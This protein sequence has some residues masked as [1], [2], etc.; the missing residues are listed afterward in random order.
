MDTEEACTSGKM[1]TAPAN[2]EVW[3]S[4]DQLCSILT[5]S[6]DT[7]VWPPGGLVDWFLANKLNS[8]ADEVIFL[9]NKVSKSANDGYRGPVYFW[10]NGDSVCKAGTPK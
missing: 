9:A 1:L 8:L 3:F 2:Q 4:W 10:K 6:A 7:S 5:S